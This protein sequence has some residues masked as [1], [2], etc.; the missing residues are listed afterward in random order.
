MA[1][2]RK[3]T[4]LTQA[5]VPIGEAGNCAAWKDSM[6]VSST[7][8]F[9]DPKEREERERVEDPRERRCEREKRL[10]KR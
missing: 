7:G 6:T 10:I 2:G 8:L 1:E 9:Q 5:Q 3:T 4:E